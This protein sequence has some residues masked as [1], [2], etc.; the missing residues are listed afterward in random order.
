MSWEQRAV[1][2][3]GHVLGIVPFGKLFHIHE[4]VCPTC[5]EPKL[6]KQIGSW[7]FYNWEI[8]TMRRVFT[9]T[10][11]NPFTWGNGEWEELT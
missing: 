10:W 4:E 2:G 8:K 7:S 5:G 9:G 1:C 11:W 3:N 6:R